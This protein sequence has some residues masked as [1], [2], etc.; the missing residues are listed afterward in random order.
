MK[1]IL[2]HCRKKSLVNTRANN[3]KFPV[4]NTTHH[5]QVS[6][7]QIPCILYFKG[8]PRPP[9]HTG[10]AAVINTAVSKINARV[11]PCTQ[12]CTRAHAG[13]K[14]ALDKVKQTINTVLHCKHLHLLNTGNSCIAGGWLTSMWNCGSPFPRLI[15]Y[16]VQQRICVH[17]REPSLLSRYFMTAVC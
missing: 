9:L 13:M 17:T 14:T 11:V 4:F 10:Y 16:D 7:E 8:K 12:K 15:N 6:T 3:S 2:Y 5:F 1:I